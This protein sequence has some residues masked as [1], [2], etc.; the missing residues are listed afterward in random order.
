MRNQVFNKFKSNSM[1]ST[2]IADVLARAQYQPKKSMQRNSQTST[3]ESSPTVEKPPVFDCSGGLNLSDSEETDDERVEK[4]VRQLSEVKQA[5][6]KAKTKKMLADINK[7]SGQQMDFAKVHDN[8][9]QIEDAKKVLM[10]YNNR[11]AVKSTH[12][13]IEFNIEELLMMGETSEKNLPG[14]SKPKSKM[15]GPSQS[16]RARAAENESDS[17]WEEVAGKK[18]KLFSIFQKPIRVKK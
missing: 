16:K 2:G 9:K 5:E 7:A 12:H 4:V 6:D 10:D 14:P 1:A 18:I 17:D 15:P 13:E 8:L 11:P 3:D